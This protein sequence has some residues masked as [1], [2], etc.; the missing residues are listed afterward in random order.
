MFNLL[1]GSMNTTK[2]NIKKII[3]YISFSPY[4]CIL[5]YGLYCAI[6]GY[7][8]DLPGSDTLYGLEAFV[9][10]LVNRVWFYIIL[11]INVLTIVTV[12]CLVYQ[13]WYFI[14]N[15]MNTSK[16][17]VSRFLFFISLGCWA[18]YFLFGI[19]SFL[20]GYKVS[21]FGNSHVVYGFE[22]LQDSLLWTLIGFSFI[23]ILPISL[24]IIVIYLVSGFINKR[25]K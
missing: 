9:D 13:L 7:N 24:L 23:P 8:Y 16:K 5:L 21:S 14:Q 17:K 10:A 4:I 15:N 11:G 19:Y 2:N 3:L 1:E 25:R 12:L 18:C 20:F 6:F 22:A